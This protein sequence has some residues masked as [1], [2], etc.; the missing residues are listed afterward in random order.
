MIRLGVNIDHVATLRQVRKV[1]YP[2]PVKA[3]SLALEAG[4]DLITAHLREDRRHIQEDDIW[5]L[6]NEGYPLNLEMAATLA[7]MEFALTVMPR[8]VCLVPEKRE[9]L[10]TEGGLDLE[11]NQTALKK[12]IA[13]LQDR[14]IQV[15]LFI[16]PEPQMMDMAKMLGATAIEIHTGTYA[17]ATTAG[18]LEKERMRIEKAA[19]Y[20]KTIGLK[21]HGGH[22]LHY[23]N[24][25]AIAAIHSIEELNIGHAIVAEAL[26]VGI[27]QAVSRMKQEIL[28]ARQNA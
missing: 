13:R 2:D 10:T 12:V 9:E 8:Y 5:R 25:Q 1:L 6:R 4:A 21:V 24:V 14:G 28:K 15:A 16:E 17:N 18:D 11:K 7:M 23:E 3:A 22:G 19:V 20:A 27:S 26:F